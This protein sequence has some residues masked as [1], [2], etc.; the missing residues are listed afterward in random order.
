MLYHLLEP[1]FDR[2]IMF[3]VFRYITFRAAAGMGTALFISLAL[4]PPV[5]RWLRRLRMGQ[6][7]R[8]EGPQ[9][10]LIKAGTPTMGGALI[11]MSTVAATLLWAELTNAAVVLAV[12]VLV[13]LGSLGFLDDYLKVVRR[14]S[15]GLV[16]RYKLVGQG[17]LGLLVAA[18]LLFFP[19][20]ADVAAT[21]TGLPF[22]ADWHV[23]MAPL[24]FVPWVMFILAGT[25]NS[26]NLTDGLDGL[27]GGLSAIA[28][29]TFGVFAYLIGRADTSRY[30]G[31]LYM[32]G[33]GELSIFCFALVGAILGFLWFNAHPAD[34]FMGD[35][36]SLAIGGAL[37]VVAILLKSE[38]LLVIIGGV[39]VI[40]AVSVMA[41]VSWFKYTAR[42]R[43]RGERLLLMAPL[44]HH[45][46]K[47]GWAESKIIVRFWILGLL[48]ALIAFSSLKIR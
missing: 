36:G 16:A 21:A 9:S 39:F 30:L 46:E 18:Y 38:F 11:I 17:L 7:V 13:W 2:H 12:V 32:P 22:L 40:E 24:L 6:V 48:F 28:A 42:Q 35:T 26:V 43:G 19:L 4:G 47:A 25:S 41:Q 23:V 15:E 37:G 8:E 10:H 14:R 5:I 44:H 45:F 27:A 1:L 29:G 20:R 34:V 3:N 31:L 33:S